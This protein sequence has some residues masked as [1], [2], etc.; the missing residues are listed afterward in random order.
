M[1][2]NGVKDIFFLGIHHP[3]AGKV[4][5]SDLKEGELNAI[6]DYANDGMKYAAKIFNDH[7]GNGHTT[8][9]FID[10]RDV[11]LP[12]DIIEDGLHLSPS[13]ARKAADL[14]WDAMADRGLVS[15][16]EGVSS[17]LSS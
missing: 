11:I 13:G 10:L 2:S 14:I 16:L 12:E 6:A 15:D 7:Y 17:T 3:K 9:T 8:V 4:G 1:A 5:C